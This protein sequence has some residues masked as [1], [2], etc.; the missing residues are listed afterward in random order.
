MT[1]LEFY[2]HSNNSESG[3]ATFT[4]RIPHAMNNHLEEISSQVNLSKNKIITMMIEYCFKNM[5]IKDYDISSS[6]SD[7]TPDKIQE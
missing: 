1:P 3:S 5:V 7:I 2:R 4:M 6:N